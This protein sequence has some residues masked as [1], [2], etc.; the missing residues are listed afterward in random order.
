MEN[1]IEKRSRNFYGLETYLG[2][3]RLNKE[4]NPDLR[5][6]AK[7]N[8]LN[9]FLG[10]PVKK[11]IKRI[12]ISGSQA[13]NFGKRTN[14]RPDDLMGEMIFWRTHIKNYIRELHQEGRKKVG[15]KPFLS[16]SY[17]NRKYH[18][19]YPI[20]YPLNIK[21]IM[22]V[23]ANYSKF[24]FDKRPEHLPLVFFECEITGAHSL[25]DYS[26]G[27]DCKTIFYERDFPEFAL[28]FQDE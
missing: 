17:E 25:R 21:N 9:D 24:L 6:F 14:W 26:D 10:A 28:T 12:R 18:F 16:W 15:V 2:F 20:A 13:L 22:E 27:N 4:G 23:M 11:G 1:V 19:R 7:K 5:V 8:E 3:P